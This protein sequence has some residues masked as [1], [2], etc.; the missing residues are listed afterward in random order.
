MRKIES[1]CVFAGSST[2]GRMEYHKTSTALGRLLASRG[3]RLVYGGGGIGLM[4]IV[5]NAA[6]EAGGEVVGIIPRDLQEREVGHG[7]L[8]RLEVVETMHE[9]KARMEELSHA[10]IALPGGLGTFEELFEVLTWG[11]LG[12]HKKPCGLLNVEGYYFPLISFLR[13]AT[14]E[15]FAAEEHRDLLL[16]ERDPEALLERFIHYVPPDFEA[17]LDAKKT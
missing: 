11:Q 2:G 5:A 7:G 16:V 1:I 13:R 3:I 9:R 4:G 12:I 8:T 6:L 14:E 15:G 10:F 17:W